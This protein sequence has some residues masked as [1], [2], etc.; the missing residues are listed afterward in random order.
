MTDYWFFNNF[1]LMEEMWEKGKNY[2]LSW[3]WRIKSI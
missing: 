2:N 3:K 1:H